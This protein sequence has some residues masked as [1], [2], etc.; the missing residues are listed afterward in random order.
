MLSLISGLG[1]ML[2]V[3]LGVVLV[4]NYL[5]PIPFI[6]FLLCLGY[7]LKHHFEVMGENEYLKN[8][9]TFLEE[10][11]NN[12]QPLTDEELELLNRINENYSKDIENK[13]KE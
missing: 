2:F 1:S 12:V 6:V 10:K 7:Y 4:Y 3:C 13:T 8:K 5:L 11:L 9:V